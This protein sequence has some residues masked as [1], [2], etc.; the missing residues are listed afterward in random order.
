MNALRLAANTARSMNPQ[1]SIGSIAFDPVLK[2][3]HDGVPVAYGH[4]TSG[5][6]V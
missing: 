6:R 4:S 2:R 3:E 1:I 5:S